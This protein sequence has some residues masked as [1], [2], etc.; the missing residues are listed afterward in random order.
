MKFLVDANVLSEAAKSE[1][2]QSVLNW[3][4]RYER[5]LAVNPIVLG[6]LQ[7]GILLL[8]SGKKRQRLLKWFAAGVAHLPVLDLDSGTGSEWARLLA[9]LR[10]KGRAMPVKDSLV[11]ASARQHR[12]SVVTRN[13]ADF[14]H[15]GVKMVNPFEE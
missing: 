1:P 3:L 13:T 12:L 8:P 5:E 7:F 11:A 6:E 4:K 2:H 10:R 15:A 14:S 9:E